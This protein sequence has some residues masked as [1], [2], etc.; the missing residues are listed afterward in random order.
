[1]TG[2]LWPLQAS[3][4]GMVIGSGASLAA[5][6][7]AGGAEANS[8]TSL[9]E[10]V[11]T[12]QKREEKFQNVPLSVTVVGESQLLDRNIAD[13][14]QLQLIAPS[15]SAHAGNGGFLTIRGVGT[16]SFARSAEGDVALI[17]DNVSVP[18]GA[19]PQDPLALF[20]VKRVEV[21]AGPQGMLFGKNAA[22]G[23]INV[24]TNAPD[25]TALSASG[26][27]DYDNRR[28]GR[29]Q[30]AV[31]LPLS[32]SSALRLSGNYYNPG[33]LYDNL[34]THEWNNQHDDGVR[35]RYLYTVTDQL[36]INIIADYDKTKGSGVG[37]TIIDAQPGSFLTNTLAAQCGI[38]P[39][40][41]NINTCLDARS[42][43]DF[44]NYGGSIQI[45]Y[46]IPAALTLTSISAARTDKSANQYDTD[47]VPINDVFNLNDAL[48]V[49]KS[50][51]QEFRLTSPANQRVEYVAGAYFY[52]STLTASGNQAGTFNVA[53]LIAAGLTLGNSFWTQGRS[54]SVAL[55]GQS[56]L[57]VTDQFSLLAGV[58]GDDD[59]V[60]ASTSKF[61]TPGSLAPFAGV[62][63][64]AASNTHQELSG[65]LGAQ[66]NIT[67]DVMVYATATK[68]YKGPAIND[69]AP[70]PTV[71]LVVKP[72]IP[73]NY[74]IGSKLNLFDHHLLLAATAYTMTVK[75]YQV[76]LLDTATAQSY[77]GNAKSLHTRGVEFS[78]LAEPTAHLSLSSSLNYNDAT[79][80]A[81][82]TFNC[83]PTQGAAQGCQL[84]ISGTNFAG[85]ADASGHQAIG[86]PKWK[87][88]NW[89]EFHVPVASVQAFLQADAMYSDA[90]DYSPV[91]DP[92][93]SFGAYW[94]FGTR[95][96]VRSAD[97]RWSVALF[98]RNLT[99]KRVPI[100]VF[101][102]PVAAQ[103]GSPGSHAQYL[104]Q[105][106]FRHIGIAMDF[107][108]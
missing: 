58:R 25:P 67:P 74:E 5:E 38:T 54:Q 8:S 1:M 104:N 77:F 103:L 86:Q 90:V 75:N 83:G 44:E 20:D 11:V 73:W 76:Q 37:W 48:T 82:T 79:Y 46:E 32:N 47:S 81:G 18:S 10:I 30:A 16:Q 63:L 26:H 78:A 97:K 84:V 23:A 41:D 50:F 42:Y 33:K 99:D 80:G 107:K 52:H 61:V 21:L 40:R 31:N 9:T 43:I 4:I 15:Y 51:S 106:S 95:L 34:F 22:A 12:A 69:Q 89:G 53:P 87:A 105:D 35:A 85:V 96:G 72:E 59:Q 94:M 66:Y 39:S 49:V 24:V 98:A 13:V 102:T 93:N 28:E 62:G 55:F 56:T 92:G 29:V 70:N 6:S 91:Y 64:L 60:G 19:N 108:F 100:A 17:I 3:L 88:I 27:I 36:Q 57:H 101:D 7:Q 71:P 68:G 2:V 65:K 14:S 45:D